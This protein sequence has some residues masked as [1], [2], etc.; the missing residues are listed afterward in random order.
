MDFITTPNLAIH[1]IWVIFFCCCHHPPSSTLPTHSISMLVQNWCI[2]QK[3]LKASNY[4]YLLVILATYIASYLI[5]ITVCDKFYIAHY[6][7]LG[8]SYLKC[9]LQVTL[10]K[11]RP[12]ILRNT[13][14]K[15]LIR[16]QIQASPRHSLCLLS[17]TFLS[18][19]AS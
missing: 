10:S 6:F 11:N 3:W 19:L 16:K 9:K 2:L 17:R 7:S 5:V 8:H 14:L 4:S 15:Y 12:S 18:C 13:I 1:V